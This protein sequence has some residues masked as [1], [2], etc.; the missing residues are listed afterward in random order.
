M[1]YNYNHALIIDD[2][3]MDMLMLKEV[4]TSLNF[5]EHIT[6]FENAVAAYNFLR[7]CEQNFPDV[8]F[9][10]LSMPGIGGFRFIER[11]EREFPHPTKFIIVSSS[12]DPS[13]IKASSKYSNI[14][15]YFIKPI[16]KIDL[17][18]ME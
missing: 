15:S 5:A 12:N 1:I 13:D 14:I 8:I 9:I 11:F 16:N 18:Y 3:K 17:S 7:K 4:I 10:D 6:A 2:N